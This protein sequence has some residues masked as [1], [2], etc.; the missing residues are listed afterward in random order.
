MNPPCASALPSKLR[1]WAGGF[2]LVLAACNLVPPPQADTTRFFI[3]STPQLPAESLPIA[4]E[5]KLRIGLNAVTVADYLKVPSLAVRSHSNE[6]DFSINA[7][8]AEPIEAGISRILRATLSASP[9]VA[10]VTSRPFSFEAARDYDVTV[11]VLQC[12]GSTA[13][14]QPAASFSAVIK[15]STAGTNPRVVARKLFAAPAAPWDGQNYGRLAALLGEAVQHLGQDI[16]AMLP[17]P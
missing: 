11:D 12:E 9:T 10:S 1:L 3:L 2:C 7:R 14:S 8:W 6:I 5:A 13:G 16:V 17:S 4:S 15:I